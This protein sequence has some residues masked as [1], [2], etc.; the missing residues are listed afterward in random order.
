MKKVHIIY[1]TPLKV[2][3]SALGEF[4]KKKMEG[5]V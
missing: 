1:R 2:L 4:R 5:G 3:T